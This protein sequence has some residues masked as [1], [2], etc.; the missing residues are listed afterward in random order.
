[1]CSL[2]EKKINVDYVN[3]IVDNMYKGIVHSLFNEFVCKLDFFWHFWAFKTLVSATRRIIKT[4]AERATGLFSLTRGLTSKDD[5]FYK[6]IS[7]IILV[8]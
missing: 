6:C 5:G 7:L 8:L 3:K 1:M 4:N 2:L